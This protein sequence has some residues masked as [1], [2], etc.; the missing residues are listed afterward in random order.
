MKELFDIQ[1][2][3]LKEYAKSNMSDVP[4]NYY[5]QTVENLVSYIEKTEIINETGIYPI[6]GD[7]FDKYDI[8]KD[9]TSYLDK[10]VY[11]V[12]KFQRLAQ[13]HVRDI[14][15]SLDKRFYGSYPTHSPKGPEFIKVKSC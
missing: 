13:S 11:N 12:P 1:I 5:L 6:Y 8:S 10:M 3:A 4:L 2:R 9:R 14:I 15:V 7:W